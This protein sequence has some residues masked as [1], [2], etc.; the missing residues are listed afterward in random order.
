MLLFLSFFLFFFLYVGHHAERTFLLHFVGLSSLFLFSFPWQSLKKMKTQFSYYVPRKD[1]LVDGHS[2]CLSADI[3][4][5]GVILFMLVCGQPP[6]QEAN[7]SETLTM[8][9]D[10]KYTVPPNISHACRE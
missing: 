6:F 7:D 10:C 3:W 4:S 2:L 9:M 8:I 5:L 1:V